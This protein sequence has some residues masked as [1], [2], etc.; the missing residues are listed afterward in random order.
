MKPKHMRP[1]NEIDTKPADPWR[2][3]FK[4]IFITIETLVAMFVLLAAVA[5]A[6]IIC[7]LSMGCLREPPIEADDEGDESTFG[8]GHEGAVKPADARCNV[9]V[10]CSF[11][12]EAGDGSGGSAAPDESSG[13]GDEDWGTSSGA[14]EAGGSSTGA[15][16]N[17]G[18]LYGSCEYG[19]ADMLYAP[20]FPSGCLCTDMCL[21]DED[22]PGGSCHPDIH[23]CVQYE[24]EDGQVL[25]REYQGSTPFCVWPEA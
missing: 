2:G 1:W 25:E 4:A 8:D 15:E 9:E 6:I 23:W 17:P 13:G 5:F 14:A 19:C 11:P 20:E 7:V 3:F 22:C 21:T 18:E 12:D 10:P 16:G 24:C